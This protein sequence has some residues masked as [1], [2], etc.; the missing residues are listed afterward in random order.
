MDGAFLSGWCAGIGG[1]KTTAE[2]G[3]VKTS[4]SWIRD[5]AELTDT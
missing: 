4:D 2:S 1:Y 3:V 5:D